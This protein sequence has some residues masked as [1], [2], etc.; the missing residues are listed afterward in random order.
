MNQ[1]ETAW[2]TTLEARDVHSGFSR[3][4]V[5]TVRM[6]DGSEVERE[7]VDHDNAVAVVALT[8]SRDIVVLRQYRQPR[9]EYVLE[10]PA[11]TL[12]IAGE[13]PI[14]A[15]HRELAEEAQHEAETLVLLTTFYNSAGWSTEKTHVYLADPVVSCAP[16]DGFQAEAEEADM[17]VVLLPFDEVVGLARRGEIPDAK[18]ALGVLLAAEHLGH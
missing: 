15:A 1:G 12:D 2:F 4:R 10:V 3:V 16:P 7:I 6:P 8:K 14:E 13:D 9:R 18:T 5:E 17:E 11:G